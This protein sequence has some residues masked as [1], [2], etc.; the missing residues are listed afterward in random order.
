MANFASHA[1]MVAR[2]KKLQADLPDTFGNALRQEAE[3]EATECKKRCPVD[4]GALRASIQA[5]GPF[6]DGRSISCNIEAGGP[7]AG[8]ALIVHEDLEAVHRVGEAKFI[9]RPLQESAQ[10]MADRI[11][12]RI[13]L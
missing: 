5:T 8:Y 7:A 9:E 3:I 4:T 1:A 12:K 11:A 13:A 10:Y 2:L 6:R